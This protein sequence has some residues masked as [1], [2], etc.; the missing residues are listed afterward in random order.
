M[1]IESPILPLL[2]ESGATFLAYGA[3]RAEDASQTIVAPARIVETF[4]ELEL[5]Y[6]AVRRGCALL[7]LPHRS[8]IRVTGDDRAEF[9]NRML[10]QE[11][12]GLAPGDVRRSFWLNRKG[13]I[14]ADLRLLQTD[15]ATLIDLDIL[16]AAH[17]VETLTEFVFSEDV[18]FEDATE[19]HH[20]LALHGLTSLA[21]LERI[22]DRTEG[23]APSELKPGHSTTLMV[24]GARVLADRQDDAGD[25]GANLLVPTES[26]RAVFERL[27]E[28][29]IAPTPDGEAPRGE[30][31]MRPTG[32][33]A[34]NIAR[35]EAGTPLFNLDFGTSNLPAESGVIDDR[36][37]FTK[38]CYLGQE[39]VARMKSL[40]HPKQT[41]VALRATSDPG[42]AH[43][44]TGSPVFTTGSDKPVGAVTSA[45]RSP[46][47]SDACVCFAQVKWDHAKA[48]ESLQIEADDARI[49]AEVQPSLAFWTR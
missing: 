16:S 35:I 33:H 18:A 37:S 7:D 32:W 13:R 19:Q 10:T 24:A 14:D 38:G 41:L 1:S 6:A 49:D 5:E 42:D 27:L 40:G 11:L 3:H 17:T 30:F 15:D 2:E 47:L 20:R 22:A 44:S 31:R 25:R 48:G 12:K 4:G 23:P 39:V 34:F 9:L 28:T 45:T 43:P 29:G 21:L 8:T 26:A 36:V 46:M